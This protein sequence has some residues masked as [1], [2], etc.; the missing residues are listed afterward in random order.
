MFNGDTCNE[1]FHLFSFSFQN[2]SIL[3]VLM[4]GWQI[5]ANFKRYQDLGDVYYGEKKRQSKGILSISSIL[6]LINVIFVFVPFM[7]GSNHV[8]FWLIRNSNISNCYHYNTMF[9]GVTQCRSNYWHPQSKF[10]Q[11]SSISFNVSNVFSFRLIN[12]RKMRHL[13]FHG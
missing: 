7:L 6:I 11:D 12:P 4:F 1:K 2:I 3:V 5:N 9:N 13:L 10:C 8:W